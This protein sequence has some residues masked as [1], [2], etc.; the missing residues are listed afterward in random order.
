MTVRYKVWI[1]IEMIDEDND[2]Y[3]EVTEPTSIFESTVLE[4]AVARMEEIEDS[5]D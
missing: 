4:E 3:E 5:H 1:S 2:I